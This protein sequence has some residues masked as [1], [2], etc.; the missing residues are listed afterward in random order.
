LFYV[1]CFAGSAFLWVVAQVLLRTSLYAGHEMTSQQ[2]T[3]TV[4]FAVTLVH[5]FQDLFFFFRRDI[6][7]DLLET[8]REPAF[9]AAAA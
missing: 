3:Y 9:A 6:R 5:Y 2:A 7:D 4:V 1:I 8:P